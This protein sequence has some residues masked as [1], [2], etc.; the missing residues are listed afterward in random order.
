MG[1]FMDRHRGGKSCILSEPFLFTHASRYIQPETWS[2]GESGGAN[3]N[4]ALGAEH[5]RRFRDVNASQM[6]SKR[7]FM[8]NDEVAPDARRRERR[9][10]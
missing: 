5:Q 9:S 4:C 3:I 10:R 1:Y 8:G 7:T 6:G 2:I